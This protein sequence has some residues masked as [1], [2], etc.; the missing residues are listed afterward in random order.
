MASAIA[1]RRHTPV[2]ELQHLWDERIRQAQDARR[3]FEGTWLSNA[4]FIA[5]QQWL[6]Y[7]RRH[8]KLRHISDVDPR[9]AG[10]ELYT[11][12]RIGEYVRAQYGELS[13]DDDRPQ[14]LVAQD[15]DT[16][17]DIVREL[18]QAAGYAWEHEWD[19]DTALRQARLHCLTFGV[20]GVRC[21]W[22]P[23]QGPVTDHHPLGPDG[24]PVQDAPTLQ[25]LAATGQLPDGSLPQF[26]PVHEGRTCWEPFTALQ[27][28]TP[29]GCHHETIFPWEIVD[30]VVPVDDV[31]DIY[32]DAAAGL[33]EDVDIASAMGLSTGQEGAAGQT[34]QQRLRGHVRLFT[35]YERPSL[36]YPDGRMAVVAGSNHTLLYAQDELPYR[37][38]GGKPHSGVVYLHWWRLPDRFWSRS[39]VEP[40]K[41]PQR[42]INKR[43]TQNV[44]IIDRGMPKVFVRKGM[45]PEN[46]AG[47]PL[48]KVE[49]EGPPQ[50]AAPVFHP[51]IGPGGWMYEDLA[52]Q[53]DNLAH[54][55]TLS[56]LRLGENPQN[57][58]TY[59]QLALLN[60]NESV[61]RS[62]IQIEHRAAI[63][64]LTELSVTD[65][66]KYWPDQKRILLAGEEDQLSRLL[67]D[68]S[69]IPEF[70]M[71]RVAKGAPQ[72]RSQAAELKKIDA[73]WAAATGSNVVGQDPQAWTSWYADS[74]EAGS[75]QQMPEPG[76]DS[77]QQMAR[78]ENMLMAEGQDPPVMDYDLL[79]VHLPEHREAMDEARASGDQQLF[80]RL[81]LHVQQHVQQAQ[82]NAAKVAA[83]QAAASPFPPAAP[84]PLPSAA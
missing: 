36:R 22:D 69:R 4:A 60:E 28:L 45:L 76:R 25:H 23:N 56:P 18:N 59:S 63:G 6:V 46:P 3:P 13:A 81:F 51:G 74:I 47:Y 50:E 31:K 80:M 66:A 16:V 83:Q 58:D 38:P 27:L 2:L 71:A 52:H 17:E 49:L 73:I 82:Q 19:A 79:P 42:I 9:Y 33:T 29:P 55:S 15:G 7:D 5:G 65:M 1:D 48:E 21:R 37:T 70:F 44:E 10:R 12:D 34:G 54:A 24:Q 40:M 61:K 20:A 64:L 53:A 57:V 84:A 14:L 26:K 62:T 68:K 32:G 39:F 35:C 78:L 75:V 11:A 72:P 77:Q 67:F 43:E 8:K 30:R 41:D